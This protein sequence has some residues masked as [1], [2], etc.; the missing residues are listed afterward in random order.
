MNKNERQKPV[1]AV[2]LRYDKASSTAPKV[3]ATGQGEVARRI[4]EAAQKAGVDIVQD[5]D[6]LEVLGRVPIGEEIPPE[7]FQAVAEILAFIYR[8]NGRYAAANS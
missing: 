5:P 2:A 1:Q 7:L 3:T 8:I 6:L 4:I